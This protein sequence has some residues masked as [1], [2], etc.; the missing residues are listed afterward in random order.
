MIFNILLGAVVRAVLDVFFLP[1]EAQH[2]LLWAAGERELM[3]F[4]NDGRIAG[5]DHKWVQDVLKV[6]VTMLLIMG[7]ETNLEKTKSMVFTTGFIWGK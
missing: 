2:G 7:L 6:S 1:Q 5:R 4:F 3:F